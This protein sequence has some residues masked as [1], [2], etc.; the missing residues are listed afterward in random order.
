MEVFFLSIRKLASWTLFL[1][2]L[3]TILFLSVLSSSL[4]EFFLIYFHQRTPNIA[5]F[6]CYKTPYIFDCYILEVKIEITSIQLP[7]MHI[8]FYFSAITQ[9]MIY[10][11]F[12]AI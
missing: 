4:S 3:F 2:I 6:N 9:N 10:I 11:Q 7:N 8:E 5:T 1:I 12:N